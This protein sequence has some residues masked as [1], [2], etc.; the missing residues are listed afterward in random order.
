MVV[1]F[2]IVSKA[3]QLLAVAALRYYL[4]SND[5]GWGINILFLTG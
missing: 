5:P 1:R 3:L 4:W 2:I